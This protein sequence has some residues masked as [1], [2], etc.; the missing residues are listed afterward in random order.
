M[1][2]AW[3]VVCTMTARAE[4]LCAT[5]HDPGS[6][7]V[8]FAISDGR[9]RWQMLKDGKPWLPPS[10]AAITRGPDGEFHMVWTWAPEI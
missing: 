8:Y 9:Y 10:H 2:F 3:L 6:S 1:K 4:Y 5:F 7:G